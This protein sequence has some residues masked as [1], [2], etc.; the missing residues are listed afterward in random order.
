MYTC[1]TTQFKNFGIGV[2]RRDP[3]T[4]H[5]TEFMHTSV[6]VGY[7]TNDEGEDY[8]EILNSYGEDWGHKGTIKLARNTEWDSR[9]G[10]NG[11][12]HK[13]AYNIP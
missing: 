1:N 10:Q 8:W 3:S 13:P 12:L 9:G 6:V 4:C 11:I 7:G 2:Y 5:E